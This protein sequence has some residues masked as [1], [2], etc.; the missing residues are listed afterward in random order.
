MLSLKITLMLHPQIPL[1]LSMVLYV[2]EIEDY[3]LPDTL[4]ELYERFILHGLRQNVTR[5]HSANA[6]EMV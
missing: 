1:N 2:Y 4:T 3:R 6:M 5:T